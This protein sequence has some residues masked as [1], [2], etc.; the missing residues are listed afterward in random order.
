MPPS[1]RWQAWDTTGVDDAGVRIKAAAGAI[2][3]QELARGQ[4]SQASG[5]TVVDLA[6]DIDAAIATASNITVRTDQT[7]LLLETSRR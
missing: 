7:R 1:P 4:G 3:S 2:E 5:R 6:I